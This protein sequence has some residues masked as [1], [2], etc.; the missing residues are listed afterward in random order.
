MK[1]KKI[2]KEEEST[3]ILKILR[4]FEIYNDFEN[5]FEENVSQEFSPKYIDKRRKNFLKEI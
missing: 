1:M 4:L 2:F 5:M 3:Q